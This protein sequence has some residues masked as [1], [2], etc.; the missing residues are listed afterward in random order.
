MARPSASET[1]VGAEMSLSAKPA[2]EGAQQAQEEH[3]DVLAH[4]EVVTSSSAGLINWR[5]SSTDRVVSSSRSVSAPPNSGSIVQQVDR[6]IVRRVAVEILQ[7][8]VP[9]QG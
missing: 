2:A 1:W 7:A 4:Q 9:V 6:P 5:I 8:E 3:L